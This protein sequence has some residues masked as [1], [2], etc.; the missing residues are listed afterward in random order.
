M[1]ERTA[2]EWTDHTWTPVVGC[3]ACS[4]ACANCYAAPMAARLEAMGQPKYAGLAIRKGSGATWTGKVTLWEAEVEAPLLKRKA[5][6]WFLTSMG[7]VFHDE[8]PD[9]FLDRLFS[10]MALARHH[11]FQVLTKRP[12]RAARYLAKNDK[13]WDLFEAV[14]RHIDGEYRD[15]SRF[16]EGDTPFPWPLPNVLIGC[17]AEDQTWADERRPAMAGI[18]AAGWRTFV[19]YEPALG[20][21]DWAGWEFLCQLISGGESG[22]RARVHHPDWHRAAR[23]W[24][25]GAG[26]PYM[27]KQWGEWGTG[28]TDLTT[29]QPVFRQFATF[30]QWVDKASTWVNGGV[31]LDRHG[32]VLRNGADFMAARDAGR[33]PVTIV[34]RQGK[35]ASGRLLDGVIHDGMPL[36]APR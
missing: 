9:A 18:A 28:Y 3:D 29:G 5:A 19:S 33:L 25:A 11:T 26:V 31:C 7:D 35:K 22:R 21:V 4:P 1:A 13:V 17:T 32:K 16:D 36:E 14:R 12:E 27:F 24:A 23:D 20:P 34:H 6:R 2:I 8:V 10:V 30:Q 15:G